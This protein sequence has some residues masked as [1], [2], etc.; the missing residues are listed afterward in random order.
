[1][2]VDAAQ[3]PRSLRQRHVPARR[4]ALRCSASS[5]SRPSSTRPTSCSK[6][7]RRAA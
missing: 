2:V 3:H 7:R 6:G 1:V 4:G 5:T